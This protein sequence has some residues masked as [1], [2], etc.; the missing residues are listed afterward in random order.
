MKKIFHAW[1]IMDHFFFFDLI[2][3]FIILWSGWFKSHDPDQKSGC[4]FLIRIKN[5][6][7]FFWS[8]SKIGVIFFDPDQKSVWFF[9]IWIKTLRDFF[10]SGSKIVVIFFDPD[11]KLSWFFLIRIK[12]Q[13]DFFW[14]RS[15]IK[16]RLTL[17]FFIQ[18]KIFYIFLDQIKK[19][20]ILLIWMV[21]LPYFSPKA[22]RE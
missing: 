7:V 8:G 9:L 5:R 12:N 6:G 18:F 13:Y 11:Q 17:F 14:S 2:Q 1:E 22:W 19:K 21:N 4:F 15:K 16:I 20:L 10:W 3:K